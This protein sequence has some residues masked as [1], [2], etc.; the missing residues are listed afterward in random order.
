[1][2]EGY[3]YSYFILDI[4]LLAVWGVLYWARKDVRQEMLAMSVPLGVIGLLLTLPYANDW[5]V[6]QTITGTIPSVEDFLFGF[7]AGGIAAVVYVE[8]FRKHVQ[9]KQMPGAVRALRLAHLW[10]AVALFSAIFFV[11]HYGLGLDSGLITILILGAGVLGILVRRPDLGQD[12][13]C[14]GALMLLIAALVYQ[15]TSWIT[16][17]WIDALWT[18]ENFGDRRF[19]GLPLEEAMFYAFF[20]AAFGPYYEEQVAGKLVEATNE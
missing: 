20:G 10:Q 9:R 1:M 4:L 18:Y 5:W 2:L 16:P 13:F 12:A 15:V 7:A 3:Q 17:G 6:P 19:L 11:L 8:L 14:S